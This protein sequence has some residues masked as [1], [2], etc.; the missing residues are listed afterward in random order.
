MDCQLRY[1][2][3]MEF[4]KVGWEIRMSADAPAPSKHLR[5]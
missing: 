3:E 5:Q 1:D 2:L 4:R